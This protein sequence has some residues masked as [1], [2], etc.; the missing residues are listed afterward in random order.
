[1]V[2]P[3]WWAFREMGRK[4]A[5]CLMRTRG[6]WKS[7][8]EDSFPLKISGFSRQI[9]SIQN[10][11]KIRLAWPTIHWIIDTLSPKKNQWIRY[12]KF[13]FISLI[14][15]R[16]SRNQKGPGLPGNYKIQITNY[17]Q[18]T[19]SKLQIT[20]KEEPFG[21]ILYAVGEE[22][23]MVFFIKPGRAVCNFGHCNLMSRN[24]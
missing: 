12:S 6:G 2:F 23:K 13:G 1:M 5:R 15:A 4:Y 8:N 10:P 11:P 22:N 14:L 24:F 7:F 18:T 20:S 19:I 3:Y 9:E 21:Q 17:K 16:T